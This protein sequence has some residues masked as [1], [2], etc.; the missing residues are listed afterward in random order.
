VGMDLSPSVARAAHKRNPGLAA[1][2]A[3]VCHLPFADGVFG[4]VVSNSTLDHFHTPDEVLVSLREIFRVLEPGGRLLLTMDN[5]VNPT[6]ALRNALPIALLNRIGL[7]PYFVGAT[8]GARKLRALL[9][10]AGFQVLETGSLMHCLRV[11]AVPACRV[12][13]R[14]PS[15]TVQRG[16]LRALVACEVLA[17]I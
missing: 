13:Q 7:V 16:W 15:K 4:A 2:C 6:I 8:F 12:I 9:E 11:L 3:D 17:A 5:P 1:I 10:Q 14:I